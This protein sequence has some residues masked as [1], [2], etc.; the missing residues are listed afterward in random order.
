MNSETVTLSL[1]E[2]KIVK[3]K[4]QCLK[5]HK[6]S[7]V[8]L[9]NVTKLIGTLSST[10]QAGLPARL[11]FRFLQQQQI[12][13]LKQTQSYLTLVKLTPMAKNE[14]L[15][16]VNNLELCNGRLVIQPQTQVLIPTDASR[17]DGRTVCRGIR[18][19][20]QW[21]KKEQGLHINQN[22]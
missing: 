18:T 20:G 12:L 16:W 9:L 2:E 8:S 19:G 10:I 17:K 22:F 4:D 7:E 13:S 14:L 5:L 3:T 11:Q 6:A 21:S 15:R 1:P